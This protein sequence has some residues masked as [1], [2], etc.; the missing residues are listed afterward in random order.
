MPE[1]L[2]QIAERVK[3]DAL[4]SGGLQDLGQKKSVRWDEKERRFKLKDGAQLD[5]SWLPIIQNAVSVGCTEADL[6]YLMGYDGK[7]AHTWFQH[8]KADNPHLKQAVD[9]GKALMKAHH[10]AEMMRVAWGYD[11]EEETFDYKSVPGP[12]GELREVQIGRT[13]HK[14]HAKPNARLM[15]FIATN[16]MP[17]QFKRTFEFN[18]KNIDINIKGELSKDQITRLAGDLLEAEVV[19]FEE[20]GN[21]VST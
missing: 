13:V 11:Y 16:L 14:R 15:E 4:E 18:K 2:K 3:D 21:E 9:A 8:L 1:Q 17:D 10:V 6:G 5:L 20:T 19:E 7:D 12:N